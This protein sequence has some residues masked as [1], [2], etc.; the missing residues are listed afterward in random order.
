MKIARTSVPRASDLG[1]DTVVASPLP[2]AWTIQLWKIVCSLLLFLSAQL[3]ETV[4]DGIDTDTIR[5]MLTVFAGPLLFGCRVSS[6][7]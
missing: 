7:L 1:L 3:F 2:V 4:L 6:S 5:Y